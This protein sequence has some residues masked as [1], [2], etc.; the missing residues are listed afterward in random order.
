MAAQRNLEIP[1][2][3]G[4]MPATVLG[5]DSDK[6]T[7][8][9][10]VVPSIFGVAPDLVA[11]LTP[12]ANRALIV[13][14]DPFWRVEPG[15]IAYDDATTA[16]ARLGQLD[17]RQ[18][19]ADLNKTLDW[20]LDRSNGRVV[21][22]GI[23]FGGSFVLRGAAQGR[24]SAGVTWH[25]S[26]MEQMLPR[27][28][29][30]TC[31]LRLH[32]GSADPITPPGTITAIRKAFAAHTNVSIVVHPGAVHGYSHDGPGFDP[33]ACHAGLEDLASLVDALLA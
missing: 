6:K 22:L 25:G 24:L 1:L 21:G 3:D 32:F 23:C 30:I 17:L 5:P 8:A 20:T 14:P 9:V 28:T 26:R 29:K 11:R 2:G 18:C 19:A 10:W 27:A 12:L 4:A 16:L 33:A 15:T 7:V 31:P 13:L